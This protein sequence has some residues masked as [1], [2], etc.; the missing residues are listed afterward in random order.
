MN[1][2][3][4]LSPEEQSLAS[5]LREWSPGAPPEHLDAAILA[6]ARTAVTTSLRRRRHPWR[7]GVASAAALILTVGVVWRTLES[8]Q[9]EIL[10][11][12]PASSP[13]MRPPEPR[14]AEAKAL[15]RAERRALPSDAPA[16][17]ALG[18][19]EAEE[20]VGGSSEPP[21]SPVPED[22]AVRAQQLRGTPAPD[23]AFQ[24]PAPPPPPPPEP[25]SEPDPMPLPSSGIAP[26]QEMSY[27]A[28]LPTDAESV[29]EQVEMRTPQA[30][31]TDMDRRR[32]RD[33]VAP[34]AGMR[35]ESSHSRSSTN[36]AA[37]AGAFEQGIETI[38]GLLQEDRLDEARRAAAELRDRFPDRPLPPDIAEIVPAPDPGS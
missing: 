1:P 15:G 5:R 30:P 25:A 21:A 13:V 28:P 20:I 6:Q 35:N 14:A 31:A 9:N 26:P 2:R 29:D 38:R 19:T 7:V 24:T 18:R 32:G 17:A 4:P 23:H 27:S 3:E 22:I 36:D 16:P 34:P 11:S 37:R 12:P 33:A 8:P 10:I